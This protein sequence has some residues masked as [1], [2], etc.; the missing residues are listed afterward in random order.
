MDAVPDKTFVLHNSEH[1]PQDP[2]NYESND[3]HMTLSI[4]NYN[5]LVPESIQYM[6][7][8]FGVSHK[9]MLIRFIWHEFHQIT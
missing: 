8:H 1:S 7:V 5:Q 9:V 3:V 6:I 2:K 4:S